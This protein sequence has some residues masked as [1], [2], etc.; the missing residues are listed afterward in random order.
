MQGTRLEFLH[1]DLLLNK[2]TSYHGSEVIDKST[3][4]DDLMLILYHFQNVI[5]IQG[6]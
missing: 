4:K 5:Q 6:E 1:A 2:R 3:V